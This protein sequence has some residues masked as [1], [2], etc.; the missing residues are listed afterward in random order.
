MNALKLKIVYP[1][2]VP[3]IIQLPAHQMLAEEGITT[4]YS[5]G[6]TTEVSA[7]RDPASERRELQKRLAELEA[8][9]PAI[10]RK[11]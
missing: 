2:E 6:D 1:L 3:K 5:N 7:R 10:L 9:A 11:T 4:V 8:A